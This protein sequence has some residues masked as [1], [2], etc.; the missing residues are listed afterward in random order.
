MKSIPDREEIFPTDLTN[1]I[2]R[3]VYQ[4]RGQI[5][6]NIEYHTQHRVISL[7]KSIATVDLIELLE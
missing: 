6:A 3:Y 5:I 2:T 7:R 1:Y 4:L